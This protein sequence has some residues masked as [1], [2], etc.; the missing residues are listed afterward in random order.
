MPLWTAG[1]ALKDLI[2][3]SP[4]IPGQLI[5]C[6]IQVL[7][8]YMAIESVSRGISINLSVKHFLLLSVWGTKKEVTELTEK[9][10]KVPNILS[11]KLIQCNCLLSHRRY[12][13]PACYRI[14]VFLHFFS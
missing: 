3:Y 14:F 7:Q 9:G 12:L 2:Q 13:P 5:F 1:S 10:M 11:N 4:E 6:P 8:C